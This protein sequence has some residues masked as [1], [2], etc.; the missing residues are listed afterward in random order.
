MAVAGLGVTVLADP[1]PYTAADAWPS[2]T[3]RGQVLEAIAVS[4]DYWSPWFDN[5]GALRFVR[6]FDPATQVVDIDLDAGYSVLREGIVENDGLLTAPN[7]IVVV[8]NAARDARA[9]VTA[10]ADVP[11]TAPNSIANIGTVRSKQYTLQISDPVQAIA[12]ANGLAQRNQVFET[13]TLSTPADPRHDGYQVIR[14]QGSNWLEL[15]WN[16][17]LTPGAPMTHTMRKSYAA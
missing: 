8:S 4:G 6:T 2:G 5:D 15:A 14:W 9:S 1:S 16:M 3:S 7:R 11:V 12:V 10:S 17:Q 13:V